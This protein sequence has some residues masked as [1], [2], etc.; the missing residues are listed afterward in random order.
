ML[1]SPSWRTVRLTLSYHRTSG[2]RND[3]ASLSDPWGFFG[4]L[5]R[6]CVA[7][8]V[9]DGAKGTHPLGPLA[10]NVVG[11][12]LIG[13]L[14]YIVT[15]RQRLGPAEAPLPDDRP[16]GIDITAH[17]HDLADSE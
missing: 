10:V 1:P 5:A 2:G 9:H 14:M 8:L 11:Y 4:G 3:E 12:L 15:A 13:L 7:G 16:I 6:Y 17:R